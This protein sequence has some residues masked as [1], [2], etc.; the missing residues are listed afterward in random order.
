MLQLE[1]V[2]K[3]FRFLDLPAEIRNMIYTYLLVVGRIFYDAKRNNA[4]GFLKPQL[5]IL[6]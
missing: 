6:R 3:S 1:D 5:A 4:R 2:P